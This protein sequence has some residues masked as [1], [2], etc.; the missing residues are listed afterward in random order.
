MNIAV[1]CS[2]RSALPE[3]YKQLAIALGTW[4]G[5]QGHTL[6]YGGKADYLRSS[7]GRNYLRGGRE[8]R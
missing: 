8:G 6:V 7:V 1:Y 5:E 4:L 3:H 2:S